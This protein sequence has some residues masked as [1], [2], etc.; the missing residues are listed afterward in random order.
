MTA[1]TLLLTV[2]LLILFFGY[3]RIPVIARY[4]G[5]AGYELK[6]GWKGGVDGDEDDE[7]DDD[8]EENDGKEDDAEE[9]GEV[10]PAEKKTS[11]TAEVKKN[12][13]SADKKARSDM[14]AVKGKVKKAAATAKSKVKSGAKSVKNGIKKATRKASRKR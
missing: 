11:D 8:E 7:E 2:I 12:I 14:K 13:R 4:I 10:K 9:G 3:K 5:S 1:F 6:K